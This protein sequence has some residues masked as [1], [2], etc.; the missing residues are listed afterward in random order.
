MLHLHLAYAQK[1]LPSIRAELQG[2]IITPLHKNTGA[3]QREERWAFL[4][5]FFLLTITISTVQ[6]LTH[7]TLSINKQL[8]K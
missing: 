4:R 6:S 5:K 8:N 1:P 3:S 2:T 7:T